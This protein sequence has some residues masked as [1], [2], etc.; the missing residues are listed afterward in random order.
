MKLHLRDRWSYFMDSIVNYHRYRLMRKTAG[1]NWFDDM[2]SVDS[3][4]KM[5]FRISDTGDYNVLIIDGRPVA[6]LTFGETAMFYRFLKKCV[7]GR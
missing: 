4:R 1:R 6:D 2:N 7:Y 3:K 5:E